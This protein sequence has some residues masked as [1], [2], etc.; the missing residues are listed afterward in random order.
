MPLEKTTR[1]II[2]I[3]DLDSRIHFY[4]YY[5]TTLHVPSGISC[6]GICVRYKAKR[7]HNVPSRYKERQKRCTTCEIFIN[8]DK[9]SY[10]PCCNYKLRTRSFRGWEMRR[11]H[12]EATIKRYNIF[13]LSS[14]G[15]SIP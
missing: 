1:S 7:N 3:T 6:N 15:I 11:K 2:T 9:T 13:V 8:W 5:Q 12:R 14:R 10:C 4:L